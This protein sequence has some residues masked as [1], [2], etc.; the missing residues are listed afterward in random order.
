MSTQSKAFAALH[1]GPDVLVLP[2]A[3][4]AGSAR[5]IES[6]GAAAIATS[7]AAVAWAHGYPDGEAVPF[8]LVLNT[9]REIARVV[10]VPITADIEAGYTGDDASC[11]DNVEY[12]VDAGAVGINIEDGT[13]S[14]QL[15]ADK[16]RAIKAELAADVWVNARTDVYLHNLAQGEAAYEET[17]KRAHLYRSAG[18]DSIFIPMAAGEDLLMR[19]V[20]A[21]DAPINVLA[22]KGV[23]PVARLKEIG[24][25][26]LSAGSGVAKVSLDHTYAITKAFLAEGASEPLTKAAVIPGGLNALMRRD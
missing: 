4:D 7:S 13:G 2:N 11:V 10:S 6:A 5:V 25:R 22:W 3:W 8:D 26:R 20:K 15:L 16:I 9:V 24:I 14:P 17:V 19:F 23:P 12:I 1:A 21:I 18:A